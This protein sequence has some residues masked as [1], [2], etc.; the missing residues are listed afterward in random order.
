M[1]HLMMAEIGCNEEYFFLE[2]VFPTVRVD[3]LLTTCTIASH[4]IVWPLVKPSL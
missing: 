2:F 1:D 3:H 4:T